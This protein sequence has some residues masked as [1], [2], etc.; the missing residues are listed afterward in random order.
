M[1]TKTTAIFGSVQLATYLLVLSFA[2]ITYFKMGHW[3]S[4]GN[5]DPKTI[6]TS[7]F[8]PFIWLLVFASLVSLGV[9]PIL[10]M[11]EGIKGIQKRWHFWIF[12]IGTFLWVL[13]TFY[14]HFMNLRQGGLLSWVFD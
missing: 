8:A 9:Y 5:P 4:Y 1:N 12:L 14:L 10:A 6:F 7:L 13:D 2:L 11:I 3:P